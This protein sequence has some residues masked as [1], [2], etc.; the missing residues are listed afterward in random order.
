MKKIKWAE[1]L[2]KIFV[3]TA[4]Q[5]SL[6]SLE[7]PSRMLLRKFVKTQEDVDAFKDEIYGYIFIGGIWAIGTTILMYTMHEYIGA[8]IN[9]I[10]QIIAMM[11]IIHRRINVIKSEQVH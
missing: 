9:L 1:L 7:L 10:F 5:A 4:V 3:T 2:G 6:G 11:W 8:I